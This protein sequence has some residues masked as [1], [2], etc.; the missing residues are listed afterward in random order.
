M[1]KM[2]KKEQN[3]SSY[4]PKPSQKISETMEQ[5]ISSLE[6]WNE[7]FDSWM[8]SI[9]HDVK[10]KNMEIEALTTASKVGGWLSDKEASELFKLASWAPEENAVC[11]ELGSWLGK[12]SVILGKA[13]RYKKNAKLY[14]I[15]P[16]DLL[17]DE[18][19]HKKAFQEQAGPTNLTRK[20]VVSD[21][22]KANDLNSVITLVEAFGENYIN[23]FNQPID[24]LFIDADHAY[25]SVVRDYKN[26]APL[27]KSGGFIAFHDY[28]KQGGAHEGPRLAVNECVVD[29][30]EWSKQWLVD[31]LFV[32]QKS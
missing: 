30:P 21:M 11:C 9:A 24:F 22:M 3:A 1:L 13:L 20:Q 18:P 8:K 17:A 27:I 2:W 26:W 7:G 25:E 6:N 15:D 12:S 5:T 32:A 31:T 23:E 28:H 14:C 10:L 16:F 29:N 4:S 19:W